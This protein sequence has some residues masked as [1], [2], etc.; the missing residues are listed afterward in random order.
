MKK[1][2]TLNQAKIKKGTRVLVRINADVPLTKTGE[3]LDDS[4]VKD[5][6]LT[7]N[8]LIKKQ[9][10]IIILNKI[11]RPD[12]K[13]VKRLS[14]IVVANKLKSLLKH[15][16]LFCDDLLGK[17]AETMVNAMKPGD[18]L[19]TENTRFW[20]GEAENDLVFAKTLARLGDVYVNEAFSVCHR[21]D[22]SVSALS[23]QL[24][25][26]AGFSLV[27][28]ITELDKVLSKKISPKIA[29][30]GGAKIDTKVDLIKNLS[31]VMDKVLLGGS[32]ANAVL[33]VQGYKV[34]KSMSSNK[35]LES[36]KKVLG[37]KLV[38]PID[39]VSAKNMTA[40]GVEV[41]VDKVDN[42]SYVFDVGSKTVSHYS[43]LIKEAK[44]VVW[45]GP[46]GLF[47][48]ENFKKG[49][50]AIASTMTKTKAYT[51]C[52]GGETLLALK[53]IKGIKKI[54]FVSMAGG[55][56]LSFLAG[57]PMPGLKNLYKE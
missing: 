34:G 24:P 27:A 26:Y 14:N 18:V 15:K 6:V 22:A 3:I 31:L 55:A 32:I 35:E 53:Q 45:N 8:Y 47:E 43:Q 16:V 37:N 10:K 5:A 17:K 9:A 50:V 7:L 20:A 56:M 21:A 40:R 11:G 52:G 54:K 36:A 48:K 19:M 49:T 33:A 51:V 30:I 29:L 46:V 28:E 23:G 4:R 12:G 38:V 1:L 39:V 2:K 25:S 42:N 57:E 44:M 13:K 41:S